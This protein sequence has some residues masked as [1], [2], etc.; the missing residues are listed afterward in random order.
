MTM[1]TV[2]WGVAPPAPKQTFGSFIN[3]TAFW[4]HGGFHEAVRTQNGDTPAVRGTL[5]LLNGHEAGNA[6]HD[7]IIFNKNPVGR[8]RQ[9]APGFIALGRI[10]QVGQAI[11]FESPLASDEQMAYAYVQANPGHLENLA[12]HA[13]QNFHEAVAKMNQPQGYGA[14][15]Y[16]QTQGSHNQVTTTTA[17][18]APPATAAPAAAPASPAA[19]PAPTPAWT[20]APAQSEVPPF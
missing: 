16:G 20:P 10:V 17:Y 6:F 8:F 14:Q 2:P 19:A 3:C 9:A 13:I 11:D 4:L 12:R 15:A 7:F 1:P 5:I 18:V